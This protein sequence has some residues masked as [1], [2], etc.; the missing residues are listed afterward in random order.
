MCTALL[1]DCRHPSCFLSVMEPSKSSEGELWPS[2]FFFLRYRSTNCPTQGSPLPHTERCAFWGNS[3][4][5][6]EPQ[7]QFL[8]RNTNHSQLWEKGAAKYTQR[9]TPVLSNISPSVCVSDARP[10][11]V[12]PSQNKPAEISL[13]SQ[14]S[15]GKVLS[16]NSSPPGASEDKRERLMDR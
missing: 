15:A 14:R 9:E 12:R 16:E 3:E 7:I 4:L 11:A 10:S 6:S 8:S 1:L 5:V 2:P 13:C